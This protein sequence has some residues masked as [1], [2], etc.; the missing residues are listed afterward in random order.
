MSSRRNFIKIG[1]A[2]VAGAAVAS[3]VEIPLMTTQSQQKDQQISQL[4]NQLNTANQQVSSL[5]DQAVTGTGFLTLNL[6]EQSLVE[7]LAE[8]IIPGDSNDPGAKEAGVIYFIDRQLAGE[9]GKSGNM[10]MQGPFI[11]TG[12]K[13]P[14]TVNKITYS[15]GSPAVRVGAGTRYQYPL[16]EREFWRASLEA[17]QA[18]AKSSQGDNFEKLSASKKEQVLK[19]LWD[20]KPTSF[21]GITPQ[22]FA[23]ELFMM[24]WAGFLMDPLHGGNKGMVGWQLTGFNGTNFGNAYGEGKTPQQL[25]VADTPTKLRPRSLAQFQKSGE[26]IPP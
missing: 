23:Y 5:K 2:A 15:D 4:Q 21:N 6:S 19:D 7:S 20:N 3:A 14:I 16:N 26:L 22:D 13:G 18:Y 17:L 9:Y 25:M 8:T 11:Q 10:Y 12:Q 24:V 1:T